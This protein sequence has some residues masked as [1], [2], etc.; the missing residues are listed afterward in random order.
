MSFFFGGKRH[1]FAI[2]IG[3]VVVVVRSNRRRTISPNWKSTLAI[4]R[5]TTDENEKILGNWH[6]M[7]IFN[8][9]SCREFSRYARGSTVF[10]DAGRE[11]GEVVFN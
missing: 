10:D 1:T 9:T 5:R 11:E 2:V 4:H 8:W 6:R 3:V 7:G